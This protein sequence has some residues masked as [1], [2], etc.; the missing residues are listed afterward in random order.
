MK[1]VALIGALI[2]LIGAVPF[3]ALANEPVK[4][5]PGAPNPP[6][7]AESEMMNDRPYSGAP[8][9]TSR[10]EMRSPDCP[11]PLLK[12]ADAK[13]DLSFEQQLKIMEI[14]QS[15]IR[16]SQPLWFALEK[17]Q[18]QLRRLW[19]EKILNQK[20]IEEKEVEVTLTR[21]KLRLL[22][23]RLMEQLNAVLTPEQQKRLQNFRPDP[24]QVRPIGPK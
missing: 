14:R 9:P 12:L 5:E 16:E 3:V 18:I 22:E 11:P 23:R 15:F 4:N 2:V 10:G 1:K 7:G 24:N 21:V 20:V 19:G 8:D 13:L 17:N 6:P